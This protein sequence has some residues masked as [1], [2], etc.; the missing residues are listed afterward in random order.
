MF[1]LKLP[2]RHSEPCIK[3]HWH[4]RPETIIESH[5]KILLK[6]P[7]LVAEYLKILAVTYAVG[8]ITLT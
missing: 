2:G 7:V 4:C 3:C 8:Q 5:I 6:L 1:I